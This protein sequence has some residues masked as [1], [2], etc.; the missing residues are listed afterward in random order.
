M[1]LR[2][3]SRVFRNPRLGLSVA[4]GLVLAT[5]VASAGEGD[6]RGEYRPGAPG[7]GDPY[8]P[9]D[10]NGGY[11]VEHYPLDV[12]YDPATDVLDGQ[13]HDPAR[14]T[15]NLSQLQPR[16]RRAHGPLDRGRRRAGRLAPRRRRAD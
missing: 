11:D 5:G 13:G 1:F 7:A 8:F 6:G 9:L 4:I 10:G 14:A 16:P 3:A 15:Q 12:T 2:R